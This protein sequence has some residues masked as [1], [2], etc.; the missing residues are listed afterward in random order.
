MFTD[1]HP[2]S[3]YKIDDNGGAKG[4]KRSIDEVKPNTTCRN[5]EYLSYTCTDT[6]NL[7]F[8]KISETIHSF[9]PSLTA[10]I[11]NTNS[12][13]KHLNNRGYDLT[14]NNNFIN[15]F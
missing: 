14:S 1:F 13:V 8:N 12:N 11:V 6:K 4:E 7:V 2:K 15:L 10:K 5:I 3:H 9:L